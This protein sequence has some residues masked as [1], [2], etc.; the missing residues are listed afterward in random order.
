MIACLTR[1]PGSKAFS[2]ARPG[3][4]F[5]LYAIYSFASAI[6]SARGGAVSSRFSSPMSSRKREGYFGAPSKLRPALSDKYS[7]FS[8]RVTA[9]KARRRSSSMP[10]S[11]TV[12]LPGKTP[13]FIAQRKT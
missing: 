4:N 1:A 8:A 7:R 10:G 6:R 13:S 2:S 12:F 11:V 3:R 9:T 5:S